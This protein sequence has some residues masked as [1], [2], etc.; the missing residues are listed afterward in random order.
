MEKEL[1]GSISS[2]E[3]LEKLIK[4]GISTKDMTRENLRDLIEHVN[5]HDLPTNEFTAPEGKKF[6]GWSLSK[7]G[8]IITELNVD[9]AKTVYA[10][11]EDEKTEKK[12]DIVPDTIDKI[13]MFTLIGLGSIGAIFAVK[14]VYNKKNEM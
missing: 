4:P 9:G 1:T 14:K 10:V 11:W 6:K 13:G 5:A 2:F 12:K 7:N 3:E 8:D